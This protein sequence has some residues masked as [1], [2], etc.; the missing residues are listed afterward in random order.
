[1]FAIGMFPSGFKTV[2]HLKDGLAYD[3]ADQKYCPTPDA[4]LPL[5][6]PNETITII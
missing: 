2:L 5:S 4:L 3:Q 1:M 6:F